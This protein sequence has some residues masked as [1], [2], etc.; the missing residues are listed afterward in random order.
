MPKEKNGALK[1]IL[2]G[3]LIG[4]ISGTIVFTI[5][6][7]QIPQMIDKTAE[8]KDVSNRDT[9]DTNVSNENT[10]GEDIPSKDISKDTPVKNID[11]LNGFVVNEWY[12]SCDGQNIVY[13]PNEP[14]YSVRVVFVGPDVCG[15]TVTL[16]LPAGSFSHVLSNNYEEFV[17]FTVTQGLYELQV[18]SDDGQME[19]VYHATLEITKSDTYEVFLK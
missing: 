13:Q 12:Y 17:D 5:T 15:W 3:T 10:S 1:R 4:V 18:F 16:M 2:E 19:T 9:L 6:T 7:G 14:Q 8:S 11:E